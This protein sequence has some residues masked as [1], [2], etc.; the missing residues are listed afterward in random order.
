MAYLSYTGPADVVLVLDELALH[1]SDMAVLFE[2]T[3]TAVFRLCFIPD[4]PE[5]VRCSAVKVTLPD[6]YVEHGPVTFTSAGILVFYTGDEWG[7]PRG[8]PT[9]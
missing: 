1:V 5:R 6:G 4:R 3:H 7:V 9:S 8:Q 2:Q